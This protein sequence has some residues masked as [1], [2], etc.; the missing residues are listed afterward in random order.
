MSLIYRIP[1]QG[2]LSRALVATIN[3][4]VIFYRICKRF[5]KITLPLAIEIMAITC[6]VS[7]ITIWYSLYGN[8]LI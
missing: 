5:R 4:A 3:D 2:V 6:I 8:G 1:E 7:A